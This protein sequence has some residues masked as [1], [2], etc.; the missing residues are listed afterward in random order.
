MPTL[1]RGQ[2]A[3]KRERIHVVSQFGHHAKVLAALLLIQVKH[4]LECTERANQ[5]TKRVV[6]RWA[7]SDA[8]G[9]LGAASAH[10]V[11]PS[12]FLR[13]CQ[14]VCWALRISAAR[15]PMMTQGA[16]V[17]PVVTRGMIDPSAIRRCSIP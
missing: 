2:G 16:M 9:V 12:H 15:S 5:T 3:S 11:P 1:D 8:P 10:E 17:F 13:R 6:D 7:Q 4:P 14:S